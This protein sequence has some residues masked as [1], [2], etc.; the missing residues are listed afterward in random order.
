[1]ECPV[2]VCSRKK[3]AIAYLFHQGLVQ[4]QTNPR[5]RFGF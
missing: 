3:H 4:P 1:M 5:N 2:E